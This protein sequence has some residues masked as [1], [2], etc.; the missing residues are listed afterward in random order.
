M[1]EIDVYIYG[2]TV[3]S[4]I[5]KLK[6][7][8]PEADTYQEIEQTFVMPGGEAAN[9]A[10]VL[11][12][13]GINTVLDGC[14]LGEETREP[15]REYLELRGIDCSKMLYQTGFPGWRD[16]VLCDGKSRTVFGWFIEYLFGERKLWTD[17]CEESIRN[18]RCVALDPF[19][20]GTSAQV[21]ALCAEHRTDYVTIDCHWKSEIAQ[22]ARALV[23]SQE[24]LEREYPNWKID[25]LLA[26]YRS[27]C[28]GLVIFTFGSREILFA[29]PG[30]EPAAFIPYSIEVID[31]LAAGDTFRAGVVYGVLQGMSDAEVVQFATACASVACTR[32]PS[33]H[34]PPKLHE[35]EALMNAR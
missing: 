8:Y 26:K 1:R 6:G 30:E 35:I 11:A 20:K 15:I 10:V 29:S 23:C 33:V 5:H 28:R 21:A 19:F 13:L 34:E 7:E 3:L 12:N 18:A 17:P 27:V 25:R 4:T 16:L 2:M 14:Y 32:F 31:T 24:F 22:R 9:C